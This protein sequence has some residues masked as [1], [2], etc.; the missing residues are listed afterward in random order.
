MIKC[1]ANCH[2][3]AVLV[4]RK[5]NY[6]NILLHFSTVEYICLPCDL[7]LQRTYSSFGG[8]LFADR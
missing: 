6:L 5:N 4:V 3:L 1:I 2:K 7:V 8:H